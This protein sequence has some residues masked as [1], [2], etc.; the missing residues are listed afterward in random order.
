MH[1]LVWRQY[2]VWPSLS[3]PN[4]D[5]LSAS[6]NT[7]QCFLYPCGQLPTSFPSSTDV[8]IIS[9]SRERIYRGEFGWGKIRFL[10]STGG[11]IET[12]SLMEVEAWILD[13]LCA[14]GLSKT[15]MQRLKAT[16]INLS[17][18]IRWKLFNYVSF[19]WCSAK[20]FALKILWNKMKLIV[21]IIEVRHGVLQLIHDSLTVFLQH[22][23]THM[24]IQ[25]LSAACQS[26]TLQVDHLC[27]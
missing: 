4:C 14:L 5:W 19:H 15:L 6:M 21:R 17:A 26:L 8:R 7:C 20:L 24:V 2:I 18:L 16:L 22:F 12:L 1:H 9:S 10:L 11:V 25:L 3:T 23:E 13:R 27:S